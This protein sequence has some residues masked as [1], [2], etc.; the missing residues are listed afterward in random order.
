MPK[1]PQ[2]KW[3]PEASSDLL[4]IVGYIADRNPRVADQLATLI[5]EKVAE[6]VNHPKLYKEST[7]VQGVREMVVHAN[8]IVVYGETPNA[9]EIVSVLH[10]GQQF[11][12]I[13]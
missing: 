8:Y 10:A 5:E 9:I 13:G 3:R 6:L 12:P 7:R 11:P 1:K 4:N 2:L